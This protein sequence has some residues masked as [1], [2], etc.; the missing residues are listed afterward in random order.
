MFDL[1]S[2]QG[3]GAHRS[4]AALPVVL[5]TRR[6]HTDLIPTR[7]CAPARPKR[8]SRLM[9]VF[10]RPV[11]RRSAGRW[12][13]FAGALAV[14]LIFA[15]PTRALRGAD[16]P[17]KNDAASEFVQR[18]FDTAVAAEKA[19]KNEEARAAFV[20][21]LERE[22]RHMPAL[23]ELSRL[24]KQLGRKDDALD[25]AVRF[26]DLWR[27]LKEKPAALVDAQKELLAFTVE[28]DPLQ[29]RAVALKR[30]YVGKLLK[31]AGEQMD[32][33]AWHS[34]RAMLL[35]AQATD[36]D[37]PDLAAGLER[38]TKEGGNELAVADESGGADPLAGV[39]PEWVAAN[40]PLHSEWDKAWTLETEHYR[41][42]TDAGYRVLKTAAHAM[43]Q[44]QVF[45]RQFHHYKTKNEAIPPAGV[46]IFK[47]HDEYKKIGQPPF[48]WAG[49]H[50]DG[51]SV[52]TFDTRGG[53]E[54]SLTGMLDVLFHEASHQFTTL[55]GG[56]SVPT[57]LNE[58]MASFFEG[59]KLLSNGKLDWN[60]V[61][62]DRLY[63]L[64]DDLRSSEPHKLADVIVG[65]V[66]D[67]RVNYPWGWGIV[68]F[69]YNAEDPD[70]KLLYRPVLHEYFQ[71]YGTA[72]HIERFT[73]F[74]ITKPKVPG[75][76]TLDQFEARFKEWIFDL[77]KQDKG[78]IDVARLFEERGDKQMKLGDARRA[79]EQYDRSLEKDPDFPPVLWKL[80]AALEGAGEGDRAA[81]TLRRWIAVT[82][83]GSTDGDPLAAQRAE[84]TER[85]AKDDSN[86][87]KLVEL[88][89]KFHAEAIALARDYDAKGF[90]RMALR[91]LRGPATALPPSAE[92]RALYFAVS[93]K[94]GVSLETWRLLF[95]ERTL[96]GFYGGGEEAFKVENG[97]IVAHIDEDTDNAK[98]PEA[99][100]TGPASTTP[101]VRKQTGF[102]FRRLFVDAQPAGDWSL[103]SEIEIGD[104]GR[105]AGLCFGKKKDG[106][107]HGVALLPEGYVDLG[108]FGVDAKTLT[109]ARVPLAKGPHKLSIEVAGTRLVASLDGAQVLE[110]EFAS[111]AELRGDFGLLAGQ[112]KSSFRDVKML[113]FDS[114]LPRRTAIGRRKEVV[115][116]EAAAASPMQRAAPGLVAY[117]D[118][119][120]PLLKVKQW[121]GNVPARGNLDDLRGWPLVLV[122]WTTAQENAVPLLPGLQALDAKC[123]PLGIPILL[124][125]NE[126]AEVVAAYVK[127]HDI[128]FPVGVDDEQ[129]T[130]ADYAIGKVQLPHAYL[131]GLDGS[132][133][134]EGNPDWKTEYGS[135]LD[136][137][138]GDLVQ[139]SRLTDLIAARAQL[140]TADKAFAS[141]DFQAA[142]TSW[143]AVVALGVVHPSVTRAKHG[144]ERCEAECLAR[145]AHANELAQQRRVL[146]AVQMLDEIGT[147]F[148][149]FD[150]VAAAR[151][152][153]ETLVKT[154]PYLTAKGLDNLLKSAEHS[155]AIKKPD[156]ARETIDKVVSKL[157]ATSDPS[158]RERADALR[159]KLP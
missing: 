104:D 55:C 82:G 27:W 39:T 152:A 100:T 3:R 18:W 131:I 105:L 122:F 15:T 155:L 35:E 92:A 71:G 72:K 80:A 102:A 51:S 14:A 47:N 138:L 78:L 1:A 146:E 98:K 118:N 147:A 22:P 52:W 16:T 58:G 70:G 119:G 95:D 21:V 49:G 132:V 76:A 139:K 83:A 25:W 42:K 136:E 90:P 59:T 130:Y 28:A 112:G 19:G 63:P 61:V 17:T 69:L 33:S 23:V 116:P 127:Q 126:P 148:D 38:I 85:I 156:A 113:E 120:P 4:R 97:A 37:H 129:K 31:L 150:S 81:G 135:Y 94:S 36:P 65:K 45:Y 57:W 67:Y 107:F 12:T 149:G 10:P 142:A 140:E 86:A 151:K 143:R 11:R 56:S 128:P 50:W 34:A 46:C 134:W 62:P 26:L 74:F 157:D 84:A 145:T 77:E 2:V 32:K 29:R 125:S 110:W 30:D 115:D 41:L 7:G 66:E 68:Y 75:I 123:K 54:G 8:R 96:K 133:V 144:L 79:V 20:R 89:T 13:F 73:E 48:E 103:S 121:I 114:S 158:L 88:R 124:V 93:D 141:G 40:D 24:D 101:A 60:L 6:L 53:G 91:T 9:H 43:E 99:P 109:R 64:L 87:K 111:R 106:L 154:T 137:P 153:R 5:E 108:R 159:S 117:H 44:V